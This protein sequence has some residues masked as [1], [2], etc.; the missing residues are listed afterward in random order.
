M[1]PFGDILQKLRSDNLWSQAQLAK[2]IGVSSS[3]IANY[4][5]GRRLPSLET[6]ITIS[7]VFGVSTDYLLGLRDEDRQM[8]DISDLSLEENTSIRAVIDCIR[9]AHKDKAI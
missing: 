2:Q 6:L 1:I 3:Q 9:S 4:E 7:R 8:L 5:M